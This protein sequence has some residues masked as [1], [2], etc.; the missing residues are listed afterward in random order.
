MRILVWW[1]I[2][3]C[4]TNQAIPCLRRGVTMAATTGSEGGT[5]GS[6]AESVPEAGKMVIN[7]HTHEEI[8]LYSHSDIFYWWPVWALG[9]ILASLTYLDGGRMAIVPEGTEARRDWRVEVAPGRIES[10]EGLILP[11]SDADTGR[12]FHLDPLAAAE[13]AGPVP[14]P[15]QPHVLMTRSPYFGTWFFLVTLVVFVSTHA[16]LRGLWEWIAVL[17]IALI[18]TVIALYGWWGTITGWF[19]LLHVQINMAGY[20]FLSIW[21]FAIW[22]V[23]TFYFDR[24]TYMIFSPGQVRIRQMI[25]EGEKVYDV[26]NLSLELQPNILIRHRIL[27]F[28]DAGDLIVRTGGSRPETLHW[29]NVLRVRSK[30]RRIERL[31]QTREV[32]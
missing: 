18:V 27:G 4:V 24:M 28:Y 13:P 3:C 5:V 9:F 32:D 1:G 16:P 19:R 25:G 14:A 8:R 31:L 29:S 11:R 15:E 2:F 23:T 12:K 17:V 6:G 20:L 7:E 26:T 30:L 21:L 22:V 10:R